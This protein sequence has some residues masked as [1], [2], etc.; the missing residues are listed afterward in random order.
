[1]SLSLANFYLIIR[2]RYM[3]THWCV[4][5]CVC[6]CVCGWVFVTF[7][8]QIRESAPPDTNKVSSLVHARHHTCRLMESKAPKAVRATV[9]A[10]NTVLPSPLPLPSPSPSWHSLALSSLLLPHPCPSLAPPLPSTP[11]P[12]PLYSCPTPAPPNLITVTIQSC[13]TL[14]G[15]NCPHLD[16]TIVTAGDQLH[17]SCGECHL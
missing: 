13:D 5:G 16:Q 12:S 11:W 9:S 17:A 6:V 2:L 14:I 1:M 10:H 15:T 4:C 3:V 8:K 7:Q